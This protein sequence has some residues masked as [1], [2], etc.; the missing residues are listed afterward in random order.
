[1]GIKE[2]AFQKGIESPK[3]FTI[4]LAVGVFGTATLASVATWKAI[5]AIDEEEDE[6][7]N[8]AVREAKLTNDDPEEYYIPLTMF[9]K[10]KIGA[11]WYV[12][13]ILSGIVTTVC[14]GGVCKEARERIAAE[15]ARSTAAE[16]SHQI[17]KDEVR[18]KIG[19]KEE[20]DIEYEAHKREIQD[21]VLTQ[22]PEDIAKRCGVENGE[23]LF[24]DPHTGQYFVSTFE[25]VK[26]ALKH[27]NHSL[28][29]GG[30]E[31]YDLQQF[32]L[33]MGGYNSDLTYRKAVQSAGLDHDA[34]EEV[35]FIEMHIEEYN[36]HEV[37]VGYLN[38]DIVDLNNY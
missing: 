33:E 20:R 35:Y 23:Q 12:P 14:G 22:L 18:K 11:P 32:I 28:S 36:G 15:V 30:E 8:D 2:K 37:S 24:F 9:E 1:M 13:S 34:I 38:F 5:R 26:R 17:Y 19:E 29:K 27:V 4:G 31:F 6:R 10:V 3:L 21:R 7:W 25:R 16:V